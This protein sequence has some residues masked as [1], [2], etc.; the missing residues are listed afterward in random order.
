MY[1]S[2]LTAAGLFRAAALCVLIVTASGI[3][4]AQNA[5]GDDTPNDKPAPR[6]TP[7]P[8]PSLERR[9]LSNIVRDQRAIWTS[10][11]RLGRGD[12]RWLAPLGIS[13]LALAAS[14]QET[15]EL[16]DNRRR[17]SISN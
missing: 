6:V 9:F 8:A 12:A 5:Q 2:F 4:V 16:S 11:F 14:D 3:A 10:P 13:T 17:I 1:S 7:T 15:G